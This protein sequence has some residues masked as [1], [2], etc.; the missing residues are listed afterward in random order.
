MR[1]SYSR[2]PR[3]PHFRLF[4]PTRFIGIYFYLL[5]F[6]SIIVYSCLVAMPSLV[7][8][9]HS[10]GS[11][12]CTVAPRTRLQYI[13]YTRRA[14]GASLNSTTSGPQHALT[15]MAPRLGSGPE[16][17]M[18]R[19]RPAGLSR[20]SVGGAQASHDSISDHS[21][22]RPASMAPRELRSPSNSTVSARCA[23]AFLASAAAR[24]S[25]AMPGSP[26]A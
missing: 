7:G 20:R 22:K 3:A 6:D 13:V 18:Q 9:L 26:S 16:R 23:A 15:A 8:T 10:T 24:S 5:L 17:D 21:G 11:P 1:A 14:R 2:T 25:P 19:A 12:M 4:F